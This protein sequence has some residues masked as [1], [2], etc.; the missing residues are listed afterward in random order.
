[1]HR[2]KLG[3]DE[4]PTDATVPISDHTSRAKVLFQMPDRN[5]AFVVLFCLLLLGLLKLVLVANNE[6][7][8]SFSPHDNYWHILSAAHWHWWRPY[9]EWTLMH[10]P[11]YSLFIAAT[12]S[13]PGR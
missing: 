5:I 6:I 12:A 2:D 13:E 7:I 8:A 4:R 3:V 11:G 10:L 9:S 1:M